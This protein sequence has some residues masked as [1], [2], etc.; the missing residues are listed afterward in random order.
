MNRLQLDEIIDRPWCP[1]PVR[2]GVTEYLQVVARLGRPYQSAAP[3]LARALALTG[4]TELVDL[5]SGTGGPWPELLAELARAGAP[6]ITVTL[7]DLHAA[8]LP[9]GQ[10]RGAP[11]TGLRRHPHPVDAR[12]VPRGLGRFRTLFSTFHHFSPA[13]ARAVL[14]D[15]VHAGD[16]IGIFEMTHRSASAVAAMLLTAPLTWLAMPLVRPW[17]ASRLA[18]TY[19][20]PAIP[21]VTTV[22]GVVSCLRTYTPEELRAMADDVAPNGYEWQAGLLRVAAPPYLPV[23]YL[24]GHPRHTNAVAAAGAP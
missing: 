23:T 24:V 7:T 16:G 22:D 9:V 6:G 3:L 5:G 10:D 21:V 4:T 14:A 12:C 2:D 20:V 19:L 13:D 11:P 8:A 15:A 17:R 1:R 18:L